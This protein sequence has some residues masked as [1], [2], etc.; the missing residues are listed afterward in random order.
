MTEICNSISE[1]A[2]FDRYLTIICS[3]NAEI[4]TFF[5]YASRATADFRII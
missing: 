4:C 3:K 2:A 1:N 5:P